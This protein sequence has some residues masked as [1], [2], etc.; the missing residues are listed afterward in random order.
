MLGTILLTTAIGSLTYF[1][2]RSRTPRRSRR[3]RSPAPSS[4]PSEEPDPSEDSHPA[5]GEPWHPDL[6]EVSWSDQLYISPDFQEVRQG[7]V[8]NAETKHP[9]VIAEAKAAGPGNVGN[10]EAVLDGLVEDA[11]P[12]AM[13]AGYDQW[14]PKLQRWYD[15]WAEQI[16]ADLLLYSQNPHFLT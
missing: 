6:E 1:A 16:E 2:F 13:A 7:G 3:S 10:T 4:A 12:E 14:G 8:W 9:R 11:S 15:G 5:T